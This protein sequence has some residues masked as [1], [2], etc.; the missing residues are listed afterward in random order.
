MLVDPAGPFD[1]FLIDGLGCGSILGNAVESDGFLVG[2][3]AHRATLSSGILHCGAM[4]VRWPAGFFCS[5]VSSD[6]TQAI[7]DTTDE[8]GC[9]TFITRRDGAVFDLESIDLLVSGIGYDRTFIGV[10]PNGDIVTQVESLDDGRFFGDFGTLS[11]PAMTGVRAVFIVGFGQDVKVV[12]D[13]IRATNI[14]NPAPRARRT[15]L[16]FDEFAFDNADTH[17][18]IRGTTQLYSR[19]GYVMGTFDETN[20][21]FTVVGDE[22]AGFTG[23][24]AVRYAAPSAELDYDCAYLDTTFLLSRLDGRA[25]AFK[26]FDLAFAEPDRGD[27]VQLAVRVRTEGGGQEIAFITHA[28]P[29]RFRVAPTAITYHMDDYFTIDLNR[30]VSVEIGGHV[31]GCY[32]T[33]GA[34]PPC[35]YATQPFQFDNF[36]LETG[37]LADTDGNGTLNLDDIARFADAFV[38]G[39][40]DADLNGDGSLNLDDI[41]LFAESFVAGCP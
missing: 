41:T 15:V 12:I 13:N 21:A 32:D 34:Q 6:R 20:G 39:A 33:C 35:G 16:D 7:Q 26:S 29:N 40:T 4:M 27:A 38:G 14:G 3:A 17:N 1:C 11:T 24:P 22:S 2:R 5:S 28:E 18:P 25:F 9:E 31:L 37:C 30:V 23:S 10:R 19:D 36:V 8:A